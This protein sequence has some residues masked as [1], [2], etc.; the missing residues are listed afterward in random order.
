MLASDGGGIAVDT[1]QLQATAGTLRAL[2]QDV[3]GTSSGMV[4]SLGSAEKGVG[5]PGAVGALSNLI[6]A[7]VGPLSLLGPLLDQLANS[8]SGSA[9]VYSTTDSAVAQHI[10]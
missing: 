7:W 6:D 4:S 8:V 2:S 9:H 1:A 3:A 5:D 10:R